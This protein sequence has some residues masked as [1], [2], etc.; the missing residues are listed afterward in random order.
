VEYN[1]SF[2]VPQGFEK[3]EPIGQNV[4]VK[5]QNGLSSIV[6]VINR[7][8]P[9]FKHI[10]FLD[11]MGD[12]TTFKDDWYQGAIEYFDDPQFVKQGTT[13]FDGLDCFWFDHT[14]QDSS[15]YYKSYQFKKG[16]K[17]FNITLTCPTYS[18][19]KLSPIW[20]RVKGSFKIKANNEGKSIKYNII[21][22]GLDRNSI[23]KKNVAQI[24]NNIPEIKNRGPLQEFEEALTTSEN[25]LNVYNQFKSLSDIATF[26]EFEE[27]VL[28]D[29]ESKIITPVGG[30]DGLPSIGLTPTSVTSEDMRL[31]SSVAPQLG[32]DTLDAQKANSIKSKSNFTLWF[33]GFLIILSFII[34]VLTMHKEDKNMFNFLKKVKA[35]NQNDCYLI[36]SGVVEK[37]ILD[38]DKLEY[39]NVLLQD[40]KNS[41]DFKNVIKDFLVPYKISLLKFFLN[42][43][44]YEDPFPVDMQNNHKQIAPSLRIIK[45][46]PSEVAMGYPIWF[47]VAFPDVALWAMKGDGHDLIIKRFGHLTEEDLIYNNEIRPVILDETIK[48]YQDFTKKPLECKNFQ[49]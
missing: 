46:N 8:L 27:H 19:T 37:K 34:F 24:Y 32:R 23:S 17:L 28:E 39:Y 9:E 10:D 16:I 5:F 35:G 3:V 45:K 29:E 1:Y 22:S 43:E 2:E 13:L 14:T 40:N 7:L 21:N 44:Y 15:F 20:Y 6:V 38:D 42:K 18:Y 25:R 12:L 11:I 48:L 26:Q 4:D 49:E 31:L 33:V 36:N 30:R 47:F 41:N